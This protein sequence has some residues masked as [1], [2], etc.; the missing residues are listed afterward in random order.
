[1]KPN[2]LRHSHPES[3]QL[4]GGRYKLV[5]QLRSG[6]FGQT[7]TAQDL[8]LP[9]HPFCVVK[10]LNPQVKSYQ[11]LQVA[12]RLFETEAQTLYRLGSHPQIPRLM[13]H[14]EENK[15]FY[16]VQEL[17]EG[18]SL[19]AEFA[20][21][22]LWD[23]SQVI[24][25]L[26]D[27]LE[28]LAFIHEHHV[29]HRDLKP[30]NLIRR[31]SDNR[32]VVIDFGAVK[33]VSTQSSA[34]P[35]KMNH[36]ISIGTQGYMPNEQ[37]AGRP[38]FSSDVYAVGM[39][40]LEALTGQHPSTIHPHPQIGELDWHALVPDSDPKLVLFLDYMLRYDFRSRYA[41]AGEALAALRSMSAELS[42]SRSPISSVNPDLSDEQPKAPLHPQGSSDLV[43]QDSSSLIAHTVPVNLHL[44][45]TQSM[46]ST[47]KAIVQSQRSR[48]LDLPTGIGIALSL[49]VG[50]F[51]W[52]ACAPAPI[53]ETVPA[54]SDKPS[55]KSSAPAKIGAA[56]P[57]L[58]AEPTTP[59]SQK[60]THSSPLAET[61]SPPEPKLSQ[62]QTSVTSNKYPNA[63]ETRS[64]PIFTPEAAQNT[65]E[66]FYRYISNKNWDAAHSLFGAKLAQQFEPS[67]YQQFQ[68]V[69]VKNLKIIDRS[70]ENI[71]LIGQNTYFY[72]NGSTQ[73]EERTYVVEMINGQPYITDSSFIR[74]IKT[75]S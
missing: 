13:A 68:Q 9:G 38:C 6:G 5:E 65:V 52:R 15:E 72:P 1:M 31:Q 50:L 37:I 42:P 64:A 63:E 51:T 48:K 28:T 73:L 75:R 70:A 2:I 21:K 18:H 59:P 40:A 61:I 25:F 56:R 4:L 55:L 26:E 16:L 12:K 67:F 32:I 47:N 22:N 69:T 44:S 11:D 24:A 66:S 45:A 54:I 27:I 58:V 30:S 7:F 34:S 33:Q 3:T 41:N 74:V 36:T 29:I 43:Y 35:S 14:F 62:P 17:I 46:E 57:D 20:T 49:G 8:H 19:D 23:D 39:I 71:S 53:T 10:Q 60:T